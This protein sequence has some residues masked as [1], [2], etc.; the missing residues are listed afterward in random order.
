M[1]LSI[2]A[3]YVL[4][5]DDVVVSNKIGA[6]KQKLVFTQDLRFGGGDADKELWMDGQF[7]ANFTIMQN[8]HFLVADAKN[9]RIQEFDAKGKFVRTFAEN[10]EGPGEF[11]GMGSLF[12]LSDGSI[13]GHDWFNGTSKFVYFDKNGKYVDTRAVVNSNYSF[14]FVTFAPSGKNFYSGYMSF[15][16]EKNTMDYHS[17]VFNDDLKP[18]KVFGSSPMGTPNNS[19]NDT[20]AFLRSIADQI[21][22]VISRNTWVASFNTDNEVLVSDVR[23]YEITKY[24]PDMKSKRATIKMDYKPRLFTEED[25][26]EMAE[27][28]M[29][30]ILEQAPQARQSLNT[31]MMMRAVKMAKL[32]EVHN[33]I[34]D[35]IPM[36]DDKF[37]VVHDYSY[38]SGKISGQVFNG[39]GECIGNF[40]F[41]GLGVWDPF[42]TRLKF[43]NGYAYAMERN[44]DG[45]NIMARYTYKL[46]R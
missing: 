29:E 43:S 14:F 23:K 10:G 38:S 22:A 16:M 30:V 9:A 2:L 25:K 33:P 11:R 28:L 8:G 4:G 35:M 1:I 15:D 26:Q 12:T 46:T 17:G 13:I 34:A 44:E 20:E 45:D 18:I 40:D 27:W 3:M 24:S 41:P 39:S 6:G 5:M 19:L 31:S 42:A 7:P 21:E 36:E 37:L 32:P